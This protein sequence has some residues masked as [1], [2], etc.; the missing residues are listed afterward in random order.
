M[1]GWII[2]AALGSIAL[3]ALLTLVLWRLNA[4][5]QKRAADGAAAARAPSGR[6]E[7][8]AGAT[9]DGGSGDRGG[10]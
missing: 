2:A 4:P 1:P 10:D 7:T 3:T 9:F 5:A 8:E 6:R